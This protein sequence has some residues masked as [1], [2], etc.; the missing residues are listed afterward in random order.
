MLA[1]LNKDSDVY[2]AASSLL[3]AF[4][5]LD[6]NRDTVIQVDELKPLLLQIGYGQLDEEGIQKIIDIFDEDGDGDMDFLEFIEFFS[7]I[8]KTLVKRNPKA[9]YT[10]VPAK[11]VVVEF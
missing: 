3:D 10:R 4:M 2:K 5:N 6:H 1:H 9:Q 8:C 11:K 7:Y